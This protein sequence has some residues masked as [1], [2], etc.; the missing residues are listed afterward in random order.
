MIELATAAGIGLAL[1]VVTG[2]P[3]GVVNVAI[4]DA[5]VAVLGIARA[6]LR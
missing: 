6:F 3:I 4:A 5:A 2:M 1:G